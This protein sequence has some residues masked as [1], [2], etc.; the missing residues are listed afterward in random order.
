[1][2]I[3]L[4][5]IFHKNF[6]NGIEHK[7]VF[8]M[9]GNIKDENLRVKNV[10]QRFKEISEA[11]FINKDI[12][13]ALI[14]WNNS[15]GTYKDLQDCK[16]KTDEATLLLEGDINDK[17]FHFDDYEDCKIIYLYY[18]KYDF[19][20]V[21]PLVTAIAGFELGVEPSAN[22]NAYFLNFQEDNAVLLNL[23]DDR[24]MELITTNL[25]FRQKILKQFRRYKL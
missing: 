23:Y 14:M 15:M 18:N 10:I 3:E 1:M 12:W 11:V 5:K 19:A 9:S 16:F 7:I 8:E 4:K 25:E 13:I 21:E 22:V 17:I 24:G 20:K 6:T 2:D